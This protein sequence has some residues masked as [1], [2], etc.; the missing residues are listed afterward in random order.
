MHEFKNPYYEGPDCVCCN[1]LKED[2]VKSIVAM[3]REQD[4]VCSDWVIALI[5]KDYEYYVAN[6]Y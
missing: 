3:L 4:S 2:V 5:E 6:Y 1:H